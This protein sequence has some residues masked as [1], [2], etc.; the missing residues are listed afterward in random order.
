MATH[1]PHEIKDA[2][3]MAMLIEAPELQ[4]KGWEHAVW[5]FAREEDLRHRIQRGH[6]HY[7]HALLMEGEHLAVGRWQEAVATELTNRKAAA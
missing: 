4:P 2:D 3:V 5:D 6:I 7:F 1:T